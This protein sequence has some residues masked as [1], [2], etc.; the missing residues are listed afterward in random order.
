MEQVIDEMFIENDPS[1][2]A[3]NDEVV[4]VMENQRD[5]LDQLQQVE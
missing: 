4:F 3:A 1:T 5:L 2:N